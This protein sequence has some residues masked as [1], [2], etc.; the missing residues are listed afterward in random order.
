MIADQDELSR[1]CFNEVRDL[2]ELAA[3]DHPGLIDNDDN[4]FGK[5]TG[6]L[7]FSEEARERGGS[8][9]GGG[10]E[11]CGGPGRQRCTHHRSIC[12]LCEFTENRHD[13]RLP[14]PGRPHPNVDGVP[15]CGEPADHFALFF[16]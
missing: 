14:G 4:A 6:R 11:S 7:G 16:S 9:T 10:F 8:D 12:L 1:R 3:T 15:G 2:S 13:G 5:A